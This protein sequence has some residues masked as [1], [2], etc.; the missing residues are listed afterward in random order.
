MYLSIGIIL[1]ALVLCTFLG[2]YRRRAAIKKVCA[3]SSCE[4]CR[5][6]SGLIAPF[7]Y[8]YNEQWDIISSRI[9][10]WQRTMGYTALFDRAAASLNMVFNDLPVYFTYQGRTWLIEFW[11]GQY[12]INTGGEIGIYYADEVLPDD[13]LRT[14]H[15]QAVDDQDMLPVSFSLFRGQNLLAEV[16]GRTWWLTAFCMGIFSRPEQLCMQAS[17]R[18]PDRDMM[19]SFLNALYEAGVAKEHVS[20]CGCELQL[21]FCG[22]DGQHYGWFRRLQRKWAQFWNRFFCKVYLKVTT[23]FCTTIDRI[24][25]LYYLLPVILRRVLS[26]RKYRK[27]RKYKKCKKCNNH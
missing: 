16:S 4:K 19:H 20:V 5:L 12:G 2:F 15:F 18:F 25:Y 23:P 17:I 9:D 24:L 7:G 10:A 27:C 26:P 1:L 14:A 13:A 22:S 6:L 21:C 8:C 11:K 3:L